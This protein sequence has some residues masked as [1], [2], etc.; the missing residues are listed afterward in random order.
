MPKCEL[1]STAGGEVSGIASRPAYLPLPLALPLFGTALLALALAALQRGR[2]DP[3]AG[4]FLT[5]ACA[6]TCHYAGF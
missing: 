4:D 3:R 2:G 1:L 6:R 5:D